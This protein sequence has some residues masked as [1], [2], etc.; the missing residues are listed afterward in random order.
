M[1][2]E[3]SPSILETPSL[4]TPNI[5]NDPIIFKSS[6]VTEEK[7]SIESVTKIEH[8]LIQ[9]FT[10]TRQPTESPFQKIVEAGV[11]PVDKHLTI[12]STTDDGIPI[13]IPSTAEVMNVIESFS[14]NLAKDNNDRDSETNHIDSSAQM[15]VIVSPKKKLLYR[16]QSQ[17]DAPSLSGQNEEVIIDD[18]QQ[19]QRLND[20]PLIETMPIQS[21]GQKR[22]LPHQQEVTSTSKRSKLSSS[23]PQRSSTM[24]SPDDHRKQQIRDSN[25]EAARRCRERRRQ[26]IDQL[27]GNLEQYKAQIKQLNDKI[28][29]AERENTQLRA[30]ISETKLFQITRENNVEFPTILSTD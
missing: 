19:F 5:T 29:R 24:E 25:R 1:E 17:T 10:Q 30:I 11:L 18:Q 26:Y 9:S 27:E 22:S 6:Y 23:T 8:D 3:F 4:S 12:P 2:L 15:G 7:T 14:K 16:S 28:V 21:K 13:E 20:I